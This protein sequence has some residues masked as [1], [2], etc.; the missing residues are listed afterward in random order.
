MRTI[1]A[2]EIGTY[3]F[4]ARA[5]WYQRNNTPSIN[6]AFLEEGTA[7]HE[8]HGKQVASAGVSL[9]AGTVLL[10]VVVILIVVGLMM[11]LLS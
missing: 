8:Q 11:V 1:R 3:L 9:R 7:H 5:W 2:S 10:L 6:E 4:C